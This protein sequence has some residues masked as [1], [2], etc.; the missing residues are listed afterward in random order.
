MGGRFDD[1]K[2]NATPVVLTNQFKWLCLSKCHSVLTYLLL[3]FFEKNVL[4]F[5]WGLFKEGV[6]SDDE[7]F[8]T[9]VQAN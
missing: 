2:P 8:E 5:I 6:S 4:F 7:C 1:S 3:M 9:H